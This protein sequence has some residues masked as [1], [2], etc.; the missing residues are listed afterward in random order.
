MHIAQAGDNI[1]EIKKLSARTDIFGDE[2][3]SSAQALV[4][5]YNVPNKNAAQLAELSLAL[6]NKCLGGIESKIQEVCE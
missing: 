1:S 6:E 5:A 4:S 3:V 2:I